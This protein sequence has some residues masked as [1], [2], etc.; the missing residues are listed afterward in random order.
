MESLSGVHFGL[1]F[2]KEPKASSRKFQPRT[3]LSG[4]RVGLYHST[5]HARVACVFVS[6]DLPLYFW[7][8]CYGNI[9]FKSGLFAAGAWR[10]TRVSLA[11]CAGA[12]LIYAKSCWTAARV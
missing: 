2:W 4:R 5:L 7:F 10:V 3:L 6:L 9:C 11:T 1:Y 8:R 12:S